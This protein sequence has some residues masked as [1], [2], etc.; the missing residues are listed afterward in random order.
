MCYHENSYTL[1]WPQLEKNLVGV[2]ENKFSIMYSRLVIF[3]G[4]LNSK[5]MLKYSFVDKQETDVPTLE[6]KLG[7]GQIEEVI[8]QVLSHAV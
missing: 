6:Q 2:H 7:A 8:K 4:D 3:Q 5:K 1:L